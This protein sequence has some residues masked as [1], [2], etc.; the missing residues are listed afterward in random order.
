MALDLAGFLAVFGTTF[1]GNPVSTNPGFSI[2][3]AT[4]ASANILGNLLGLLGTPQGLIGSHDKYEGDVSATRGD[5]Y[6]AG[7]NYKVI[8]SQ[9][10]QY[11]SYILPNTPSDQ[12]YEALFTF[13]QAR[14]N[15]SLSQNPYFFYAPFAGLF[16]NPA[17]YSFPKAM[18][19]NH[20]A[21]F[22]DGSLSAANFK[23]F[24]GLSGDGS[25]LSYQEGHEQIP[26]NWYRRPIGN[27][28]S[29]P[30]Y[31]V[32]LFDHAAKDPRFINIGGN[33][34][35]VNTFAPVDFSSLTGGVFTGAQ[36]LKG[37][38]L[39]CFIFQA[40]LAASPDLLGGL[41]TSVT[42]ALAP[43]TNTINQR[44]AGLGCPQ[45]SSYNT[46]LLKNYPG[47]VRSGGAI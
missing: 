13:R 47:Y 15:T 41:V 26:T 36:I 10:Q 23:S 40:I 38:N 42:Q 9:A 31:L 24:F 34:N 44:L 11:L 17:G 16:A 5:L 39:E 20:S 14:Y 27:E 32:D 37:N 29:I 6:T 30:L 22:P 18:M 7:N 4:A 2:G 28:Y 35:G 21:Q 1:T 12:L 3:G 43:L 46:A 8:L 33:V 19:A 45:L 25:S